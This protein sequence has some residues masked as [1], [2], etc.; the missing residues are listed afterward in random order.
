MSF[1]HPVRTTTAGVDPNVTRR[2]CLLA[3]MSLSAIAADTSNSAFGQAC[4][5]IVLTSQRAAQDHSFAAMH[6]KP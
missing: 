5:R 2:I 3:L 4:V 6:K 1:E